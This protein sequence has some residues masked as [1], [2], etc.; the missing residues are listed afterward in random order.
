VTVQISELAELEARAAE[1]D[2]AVDATPG[3]DPFCSRSAWTLS[4]HRAFGADRDLR[5]CAGD[6]SFALLARAHHPRLGPYLEPLES[7]WGLACPL[8]GPHAVELLEHA[9][10][11]AAGAERGLPLMLL[12]LP[13]GGPL[14]AALVRSLR[15]RYE[16]RALPD[17]VRAVASLG[18]GLEGF[19]GRRSAAFRRNLRA[20]LR[21]LDPQAIRFEWL[22]PTP[23]EVDALYARVLAIERLS[24]KA[25]AGSGVDSG[26]MADFYAAM[27]PRLARAGALRV[28][29]AR[30]GERDV[31]YLHGGR[32]GARFRGLQ[33]SFDRG[34]RAL[35]LGNALQWEAIRHLCAEGCE[36]YDLG[37]T[38]PYKRRWAECSEPS[39]ALLALPR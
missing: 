19:L 30:A 15:L 25:A 5:A 6:A 1:L 23:A 33:F 29:I 18:G 35:S 26:A 12:G 17:S 3:T 9:L 7:M 13:P 2:R 39:R 28:L 38:A 16:L 8:L 32:A 34:L 20:G 22:R 31:G 24:W 27:W 21:R 10:G 36:R 14:L 4:F 37:A 11:A